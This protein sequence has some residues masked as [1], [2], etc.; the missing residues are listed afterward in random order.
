MEESDDKM[1]PAPVEEPGEEGALDRQMGS[2]GQV[3]LLGVP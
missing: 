1:Q 3:W 2:A